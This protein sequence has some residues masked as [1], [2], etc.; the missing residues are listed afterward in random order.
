M[1]TIDKELMY[2][3]QCKD[4][5]RAEI[6][7]CASCEVD[8]ISG[9]QMLA[10]TSSGPRVLGTIGE[11]DKLTSLQA[12]S[13]MEMKKIKGML[14]KAGIPALLIKDENCSGGCCG[15]EVTLH[16]KLEDLGAA[17]ELLFAEHQRSTGLQSYN[18][19]NVDAVFDPQ[20]ATVN[21]PACGTQFSPSLGH[22]PD[23]G[24]QFM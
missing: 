14:E 17:Q 4:E 12:G 7:R 1:Q 10:S 3:P 11:S 18:L 15:P 6:E 23:C 8:L 5:Y 20:A 19:E 9:E 16:I 24:L 2:C 13:L 21:C 22:C